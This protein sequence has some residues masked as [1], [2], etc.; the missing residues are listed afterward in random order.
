M[1]SATLEDIQ[2][3]VDRAR[4]KHPDFTDGGKVSP[5]MILSEEIGE[6]AEAF[7]RSDRS[8]EYFEEIRDA[9]AVLVRMYEGDDRPRGTFF[10]QTAVN[11]YYR[12]GSCRQ[13]FDLSGITFDG[14]QLSFCPACGKPVS[15]LHAFDEAFGYVA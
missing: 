2:Q 7:A 6:V 8:V 9:I 15:E 3:A 12:C 5:F 10:Q 1:I 4:K 13:F 11:G 14:K